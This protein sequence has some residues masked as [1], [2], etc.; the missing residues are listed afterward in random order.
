M[1][2]NMVRHPN[3]GAVLVVGLGCEN[4]Q[5]DA[6]RETLGDFDPDRVH[7]MVCQ[8]QEDEVEAGLEHLHQLYEV[9]RNDKRQPG[10]LSELKFGL[11]CGGSD[12]LSGITA[13]PMLGRFS[14]YVIGNG[15]TTVLTEVPS[16]SGCN[17]L[18]R[19]PARRASGCFQSCGAAEWR[20]PIR[21]AGS[22]RRSAF[23]HT[24]ARLLSGEDG[25]HAP[26]YARFVHPLTQVT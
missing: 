23:F 6:F 26:A 25:G 3:A 24:R 13:N 20:S 18:N 15:G 17:S 16:C 11:E 19:L 10:K 22:A 4:N 9:M 7:F 21:A 8:H 12:G 2:Q 14:D 5:V 1:L